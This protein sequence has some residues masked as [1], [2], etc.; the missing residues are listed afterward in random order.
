MRL[1]RRTPGWL[2]AALAAA[3]LCACT[4]TP[5]G[6]ANRYEGREGGQMEAV[7]GNQE[8]ARKLALK[9]V[10]S[11]RE[12]GRMIV[13]FDLTNKKSTRLEFAWTIEWL[14]AAGFVIPGSDRHWEPISM[15]GYAVETLTAVAPRPEATQWRLQVTSRNEVK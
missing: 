9:N 1:Q 3:L 4:T 2:T 7:E 8:L 6:S 10:L 13:Q 11:K 5:R 15:G 12:D 14:D